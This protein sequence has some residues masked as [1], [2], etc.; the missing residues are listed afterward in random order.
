LLSAPSLTSSNE[1]TSSSSMGAP[2]LEHIFL[3]PREFNIDDPTSSIPSIRFNADVAS[4]KSGYDNFSIYIGNSEGC[5]G[6]DNFIF[7]GDKFTGDGIPT[8]FVLY[9]DVVPKTTVE[10]LEKETIALN[11]IQNYCD[12]REAGCVPGEFL[13]ITVLFK[14]QIDALQSV[15]YWRQITGPTQKYYEVNVVSDVRRNRRST[16]AEVPQR[17]F[18]F[19]FED[20]S[21][22]V[23]SRTPKSSPTQT[24]S[25]PPQTTPGAPDGVRVLIIVAVI[26]PTILVLFITIFVVARIKKQNESTKVVPF[27]FWMRQEDGGKIHF[28]KC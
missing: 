19:S 1:D 9:A 11:R 28:S 4:W 13:R 8:C 24:T 23:R 10:N 27:P 16:S 15:L 5:A 21:L 22:M 25:I 14:F 7:Q 12:Q 26:V 6:R 3:N 20:G 18:V 2:E 17:F